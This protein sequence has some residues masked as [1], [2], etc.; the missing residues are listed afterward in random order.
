MVDD[1]DFEWLNQF[2][3][4]AHRIGNSY[5]AVAWIPYDGKRKQ[6]AMHRMILNTP[7][8][9][10][11]DHRNGDG[12]DN[13]RCNLRICSSSQNI[14]NSKKGSRRSSRF[15]G[16]YWEKARQKWHVEIQAFGKKHHLGRFEK[17]KDAA[18]A[19][20]LAARKHFGRFARLN[21]EAAD[22]NAE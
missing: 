15:K 22:A 4:C 13:Q 3:W 8:D 20:D 7:S 16:V 17:E 6:I 2:K 21:L 19:Y 12:L 10:Q 14:M 9:M 18:I 1:A 11:S 5:Y